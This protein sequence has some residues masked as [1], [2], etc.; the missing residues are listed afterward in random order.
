MKKVPWLKLTFIEKKKFI[1]C[2]DTIKSMKLF[3]LKLTYKEN[4]ISLDEALLIVDLQ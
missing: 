3:G 4:D 1:N 2:S